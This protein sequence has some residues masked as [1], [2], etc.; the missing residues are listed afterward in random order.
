[1]ST[2]NTWA[3]ATVRNDWG[4]AISNVQL[5]HRYDNDHFDE[6][7]WEFIADQSQGDSFDVG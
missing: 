4:G 5:K 3:K 6:K 2:P 7:S 1:M